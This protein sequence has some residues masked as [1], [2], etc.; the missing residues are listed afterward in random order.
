LV[1]NLQNKVV[2]DG[3]MLVSEK[4]F[5]KKRVRGRVLEIEQKMGF[6]ISLLGPIL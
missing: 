5:A 6:C 2:Q 1:K 4:W 3:S